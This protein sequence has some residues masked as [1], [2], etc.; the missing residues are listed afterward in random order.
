VLVA[1]G[2]Y[3]SYANCGLPYLR[4][5]S[6]LRAVEALR[7]DPGK[8]GRREHRC[9]GPPEGHLIDRAAKTVALTELKTGKTYAETYDALYS[10]GAER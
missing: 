6:D 1:R 5:R 4:R 7:D 9:S 8:F 3:V 2:D 10:P